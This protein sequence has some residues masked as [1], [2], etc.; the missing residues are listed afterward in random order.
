VYAILFKALLPIELMAREPRC[1]VS[2]YYCCIGVNEVFIHLSKSLSLL[3]GRTT[4]NVLI[5]V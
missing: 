2:G 5:H 3:N 1:C 4:L